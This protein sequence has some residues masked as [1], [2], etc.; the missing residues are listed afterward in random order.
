M[1]NVCGS[2]DLSLQRLAWP[3]FNSQPRCNTRAGCKQQHED[4]VGAC[5][6]TKCFTHIRR[7]EQALEP[8]EVVEQKIVVADQ[9]C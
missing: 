3:I 5:S 8:A 1:E 4:F 9:H 7:L 6:S 2:F